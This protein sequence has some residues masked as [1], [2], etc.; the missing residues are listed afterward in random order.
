MADV[1]EQLL[2]D[3]VHSGSNQTLKKSRKL[4]TSVCLLYQIPILENFWVRPCTTG[5]FIEKN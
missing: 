4:A 3:S 1:V 2:N 5:T